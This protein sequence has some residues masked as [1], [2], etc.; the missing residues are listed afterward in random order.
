M[1]LKKN[2][3]GSICS[4]A[5]R[6]HNLTHTHT[7]TSYT[8]PYTHAQYTHTHIHTPTPTGD[9]LGRCS[10]ARSKLYLAVLDVFRDLGITFSLPPMAGYSAPTIAHSIAN[11]HAGHPHGARANVHASPHSVPCS[12]GMIMHWCCV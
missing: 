3:R 2:E 12:S 4:V 10:I 6:R 9:D 5:L 11:S 7:H 8:H 1:C